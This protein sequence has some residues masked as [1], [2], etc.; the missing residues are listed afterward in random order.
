MVRT[1][2]S[3]WQR[4]LQYGGELDVAIADRNVVIAAT[5]ALGLKVFEVDCA[6]VRS[7]SAL[8]RAIA[9]AVDF[10]LPFSD[11]QD[12][13]ECLCD[14]V[15]DQTVGAVLW[16]KKLHSG[17]PALKD[18]AACIVS[19]CVEAT[20][21]SRKHHRLFAYVI[22]HAGAHPTVESDMPPVSSH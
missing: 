10:P 2:Q 20:E 19:V 16:L 17:D 14:T 9:H 1:D 21:F 18:E 4:Q 11:V 6:R 22:E 5:K 7:R 8:F 12:L 13:Y 3:V 15:L